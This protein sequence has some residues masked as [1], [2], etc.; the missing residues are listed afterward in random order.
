[1]TQ[2]DKSL[3]ELRSWFTAHPKALVAFSGGVDSCLV[4]FLA[5]KFLGKDNAIA[6]ISDSPSLKRSDLDDAHRFCDTHDIR[7]HV[8][9][10][11]EINDPNYRNNP[12][13]RCFHCKT[14]LYHTMQGLL[15]NGYAGFELLNGANRNDQGDYRPGM[16]AAGQHS[17]LSPLLECGV[18]KEG[19]R[20]LARSMGLFTWDKP[21]SPCLSSR[22][23][24]G[25][26]IS[27]EK[28]E[29]VERGEEYLKSLG[30]SDCRVRFRDSEA[31]LEVPQDEVEKLTS[32]FATTET[33]F[34]QIGFKGVRIDP[35]GLVSGKLNRGVIRGH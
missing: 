2:T 34:L 6:V 11:G 32:V 16:K 5:R 24:Y 3:E 17:V 28:L 10:A 14:A 23:P 20:A 12:I 15:E 33:H 1:M 26:A 4:A 31:T 8:I 22:F 27:L 9:D 30:F 18:D 7:L 25:E 21:A 19:V 29:M 35:E 13:D